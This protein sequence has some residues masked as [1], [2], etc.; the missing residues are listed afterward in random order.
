MQTPSFQVDGIEVIKHFELRGNNTM[1]R[2]YMDIHG[3]HIVG[4]RKQIEDLH[5][6][7][8]QALNA[9]N[10][11]AVMPNVEPLEVAQVAGIT[12]THVKIED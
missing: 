11:E 6:L 3:L 4:T 7:C 5:D 9:K 10:G 8:F 12:P 2:I 1:K